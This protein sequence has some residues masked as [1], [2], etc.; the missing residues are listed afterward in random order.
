MISGQSAF[1][2][3]A[4]VLQATAAGCFPACSG[5]ANRSNAYKGWVTV[6][7]TM[8]VTILHGE[9]SNN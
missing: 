2:D 7:V 8:T 1:R 4:A 6:T 9:Q 3:G 5:G